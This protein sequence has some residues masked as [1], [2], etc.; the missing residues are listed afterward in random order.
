MLRVRLLKTIT[1]LSCA[2]VCGT[3]G[4]YGVIS[5]S[6]RG[7]CR[8]IVYTPIA[9]RQLQYMLRAIVLRTAMCGVRGVHKATTCSR[10]GGAKTNSKRNETRVGLGLPHVLKGN[11]RDN[12][13]KSIPGI[14]H[15]ERVSTHESSRKDAYFV[16]SAARSKPQQHTNTDHHTALV[17]GWFVMR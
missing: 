2:G 11:R 9:L 7:T 8:V 15:W 17:Q 12:R 10:R 16:R 5:C 14:P 13:E 4:V 6:P 1:G 3:S